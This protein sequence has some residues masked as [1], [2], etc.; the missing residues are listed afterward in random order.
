MPVNHSLEFAASSSS[1]ILVMYSSAD[2]QSTV[3]DKI[4]NCARLSS[5]H[6]YEVES[7]SFDVALITEQHQ[8]QH[9][10]QPY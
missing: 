1:L 4:D 6:P 7:N 10:Q 9:Q 8:K 5:G 2:P 3:C